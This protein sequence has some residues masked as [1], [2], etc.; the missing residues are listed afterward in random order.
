MTSDQFQQYLNQQGQK[1]NT[2]YYRQNMPSGVADT[3]SKQLGI[4]KDQLYQMYGAYAK[5]NPLSANATPWMIQGLNAGPGAASNPY[6]SGA[7]PWIQQQVNNQAAQ[8]ILNPQQQQ[9]QFQMPQLSAAQPTPAAPTITPLT[10]T[11]Q[12]G[13]T[14]QAAPATTM[15]VPQANAG[16]AAP[17]FSLGSG[18]NWMLPQA[19]SNQQPIQRF[20]SGGPVQSSNQPATGYQTGDP[21]VGWND[22]LYAGSA[23]GA[24]ALGMPLVV[25]PTPSGQP[26]SK[27]GVAAVGQPTNYGYAPYTGGPITLPGG[28]TFS[29]E[30]VAAFSPADWQEVGK[31]GIKQ[32]MPASIAG[33]PWATQPGLFNKAAMPTVGSAQAAGWTGPAN[34]PLTAQT[35]ANAAQMPQMNVTPAANAATATPSQITRQDTDRVPAM[36]TPG[37]FVMNREAVSQIGPQNLE[38]MN[39]MGGG[40]PPAP[41]GAQG[42]GI[43]FATQPTPQAPQMSAFQQGFQHG[44]MGLKAQPPA[45]AQKMQ[46]GG[47][48][49]P[50]DRQGPVFMQT[51]G[52]VQS[53]GQLPATVGDWEAQNPPR[54]GDWMD[55]QRNSDLISRVLGLHPEQQAART[56]QPVS[57]PAQP[58]AP[59]APT[60]GVRPGMTVQPG[61]QIGAGQPGGVAGV[62]TTPWQANMQANMAAHPGATTAMNVVGGIGSAISDAV[63]KW[64]SSIGS[65][66]IQ[67]NAIPGPENFRYQAPQLQDRRM[68]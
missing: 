27:S 17:M 31:V 28:Q 15:N 30:Q 38:A 63:N 29:A 1:Y 44:A 40:P 67:P 8:A 59:T 49:Y 19:Q 55:Q 26:S 2:D 4:S 9:P 46:T 50:Q 23:L 54:V 48:V 37:E 60:A 64:A 3:Q 57:T 52:Y 34:M 7:Y 47:Y 32:P 14:T 33:G 12:Y 24:F 35:P 39:R 13:A 65:W 6:M 20:Q 42:A 53:L 68:V 11:P 51:G 25:N 62:G 61:S 45:G 21:N 41:G 22:P 16:A 58:T 43:A 10:A 5:Q 66:R 36:L 56:Q 18:Q